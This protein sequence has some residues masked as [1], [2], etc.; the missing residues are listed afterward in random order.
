MLKSRRGLLAAGLAVA[1]VGALGVAST[2]NAGAEQVSGDQ[3]AAT[4]PVADQADASAASTPPPTLPWGGK[5]QRARRGRDGTS[6]RSLKNQG[7]QVAAP[8]QGHT[9]D[10]A[11]KGRSSK[12]GLLRSEPTDL[13]PPAPPAS[14]SATTTAPA[15]KTTTPA[16][17]SPTTAPAT[18]APTTT[19]PT[20]TAPVAPLAA[21]SAAAGTTNTA[22]SV[23]AST[24]PPE[25]GNGST[26]KSAKFSY[27]IGSQDAVADGMYAAIDIKKPV[28]AKGEYH[29]LAE[30]AVQT[31]DGYQTVE[32]GWNVDR[33]V[34]G[35][36]DPHIFVFHW[37]NNVPACY[38]GCGFLPYDGG[39]KAGD[40]LPVD[41]LKKFGI[42]HFNNAWWIA[43]D[44]TYVG[45]FP[46][47]LWTGQGVDF[48]QGQYFQAF[49]EVAA[50]T[51][52]PCSQMGSGQKVNDEK[53]TGARI[54]SV[55]FINGPAVN[56]SMY[57]DNAVYGISPILKS[58][59]SF[60]YGGPGASDP[61]NTAPDIAKISPKA[62]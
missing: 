48:T 28:L 20:T 1:V 19:A 22:P 23:A 58:V 40:T 55:T 41:T 61:D 43:Y 35:D 34:N 46:D 11:P 18:T 44:T 49:G 17:T 6:S 54:G 31:A 51:T 4:A 30:L 13:Q 3:G 10:F 5:P 14:P 47:K 56:L 12:T 42:E 52:Q 57:S 24:T 37:V 21:T 36:D 26:S 9:V 8:R 27:T 45:S 53:G 60:R 38:N 29:T 16:T 62:C 7:L 59:K 25:T 33:A 15:D 32:V 50:P 39:V 2:M